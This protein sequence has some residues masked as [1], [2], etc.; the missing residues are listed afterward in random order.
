[1]ATA[2]FNISNSSCVSAN[3]FLNLIISAFVV[4]S[5]F[6]ISIGLYKLIHL[7]SVAFATPYYSLINSV[8]DFPELYKL[9]IICLNSSSYLVPLLIINTI[10]LL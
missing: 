3:C 6:A 7:Y 4:T 2:F 1:M 9:T 5:P 8:I 10:P